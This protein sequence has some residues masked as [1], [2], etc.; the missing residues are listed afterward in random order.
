MEII[1][2][3]KPN[4]YHFLF[5]AYFIAIFIRQI[6]N[7][8]VEGSGHVKADYMFLLYSYVL[9][10]FLS[11]IPFL[12]SRCLSKSKER[13]DSNKLIEEYVE[14]KTP[15]KYKWKNLIKPVLMVSIFGFFAEAPMYLVSMLSDKY[16][17]SVYRMGIYSILN[18]VLIYIVGYIILNAYFYRHHYLSLGINF[19]CFLTSLTIDIIL[20]VVK[21]VN[22]TGYYIYVIIRI[23]RLIFLCVLYCFSK[24]EF[25][26]SLLTPYSIIAFRA[27]F[28]TIFLGLF[29]IPF[30]LIPVIDYN[31]EVGE[32]IFVKFIFQL[33]NINLLY[34]IIL[35]I[36][37]YIID[38][39]FM[40]II[41][42][43][44]VSHLALAI[45]LESFAEKLYYIIKSKG[46]V[47]W[48]NYV[49]LGLYFLVFIGAMIHNEIFVINKCGLNKK[50]QK[51]LNDEFNKE[52]SSIERE[53]AN[54]DKSSNSS[55]KSDTS[56]S[57]HS[58]QTSN[59]GWE[60][61]EKSQI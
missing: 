48:D 40:L 32:I 30:A 14:I 52:N 45:T 54:L 7:N 35:F 49:N 25:E 3:Q 57:T 4:K 60:I 27:I 51:Y 36:I 31:K 18:S 28:E 61:I 41:E 10:H 9:S 6:V 46:K 33:T 53:L 43:F 58:N 16:H 17:N 21:N 15:K 50:T 42:K 44:S 47:S 26:S 20:L 1:T 22:Y 37:N 19:I 38:I 11:F 39:S 2:F 34:T 56:N 29:S 12:L 8:Y 5:L 59:G 55:Y 23:L 24:N 13:H